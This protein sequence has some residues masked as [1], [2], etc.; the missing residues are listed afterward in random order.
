MGECQSCF[1]NEKE[2]II[3]QEKGPNERIKEEGTYSKI[4]F[5]QKK[6]IL[7]KNMSKLFIQE[8]LKWKDI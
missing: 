5:K 4:I 2:L 6:M 8:K 1:K 7:M 3:V